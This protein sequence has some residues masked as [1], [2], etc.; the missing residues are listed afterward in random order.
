ML[1]AANRQLQ[2]AAAGRRRCAVG[3]GGA[4]ARRTLLPA[5]SSSAASPNAFPT[6]S[7][8]MGQNFW[9]ARIMQYTAMASC[10]LPYLVLDF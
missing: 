10:S 5:A 7:V 2:G 8:K 9:T 1:Q 3:R 6:Q 4:P